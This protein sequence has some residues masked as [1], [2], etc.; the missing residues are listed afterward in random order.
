MLEAL[1]SG[2][3]PHGGIAFGLDRIVM[4]LAGEETIREV[5]AF[6]K[7]QSAVDLTL[8]APSPVTEQQLADLHLL[9]RHE[10]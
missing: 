6:P 3:P 4:L 1:E 9:L 2:A 10:V 7:N 5:I 8:N